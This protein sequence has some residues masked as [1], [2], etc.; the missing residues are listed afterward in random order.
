MMVCNKFVSLKYFMLLY[1]HKCFTGKYMYMQTTRKICTKL[2]PGPAWR[3]FEDIEDI[4]SRFCMVVCAKLPSAGWK[5]A[6][7][8]F[9]KFTEA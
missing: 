1:R 6:S 9:V 5:M 2:H 7:D 4:I 3:I 8:R